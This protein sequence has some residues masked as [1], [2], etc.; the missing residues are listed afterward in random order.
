MN[1][2]S[3]PPPLRGDQQRW[4]YHF[5]HMALRA[6]AFAEP[7]MTVASLRDPEM[8]RALIDAVLDQVG[9]FYDLDEQQVRALAR[10]FKTKVCKVGEHQIHVVSMPPPQAPAECYFVGIVSLNDTGVSYYTLERS[11]FDGRM[12]CGWDRK[13]THLNY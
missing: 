5:A 6:F 10:G 8:A 7:D 2:W 12:L 1:L 3:G 11:V 4:H 13:G 9:E